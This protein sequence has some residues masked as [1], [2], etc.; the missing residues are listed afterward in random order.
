MN[1]ELVLQK[2]EF[3]ETKDNFQTQKS[4]YRINYVFF[5]QSFF[6]DAPVRSY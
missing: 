1:I 2:F 4:Y 3:L 5:L 6:G